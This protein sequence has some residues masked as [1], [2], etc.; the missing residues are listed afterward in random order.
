MA[1]FNKMT[2]WEVERRLEALYEFRNLLIEY[3]NNVEQVDYLRVAPND[4]ALA[5]RRRI[6][7][8]MD[9]VRTTMYSAGLDTM[10]TVRDPAVIGGRSRS[11]SLLENWNLIPTFD[12]DPNVLLDFV[13]Q[14]IGKYKNN[15]GKA[16]RRTFNPF[17]WL[18]ELIEYVL[19]IPFRFLVNVGLVKKTTLENNSV[20]GLL[21]AIVLFIG[22]LITYAVGVLTIAEKLG[23]QN[24][25]KVLIKRWIP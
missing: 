7:E 18:N 20:W 17:F 13:E 11:L 10:V 22:T 21:R 14:A 12:G 6:N 16:I 3:Y 9:M 5:A 4:Q 19:G 8:I 24:A 2:I 15:N 23:Y 1:A 25:I